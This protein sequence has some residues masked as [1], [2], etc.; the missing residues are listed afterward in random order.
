MSKWKKTTLC[1]TGL[2]GIGG[3][4]ALYL[5]NTGNL[6]MYVPMAAVNCGECHGNDLK[7]TELAPALLDSE[8]KYGDTVV[9]LIESITQRHTGS[10]FEA[11]SMT[12]W[13]RSGL[14]RLREAG[15]SMNSRI[16][17]LATLS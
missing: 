15:L 17:L 4:V 8:L 12:T 9:Q 7:G 16:S 13:P 3:S 14:K 11:M 2:F 1:I 6:D 10:N 5:W